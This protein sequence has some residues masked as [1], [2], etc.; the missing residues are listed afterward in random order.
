MYS[1]AYA[2]TP[3]SFS[4]YFCPSLEATM[5]APFMVILSQVKGITWFPFVSIT[6]YFPFFFAVDRPLYHSKYPLSYSKGT[7]VLPCRSI[8]PHFPS[9]SSKEP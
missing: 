3:F 4:R 5:D 8:R 7:T 2:M 6:P 9:L 1:K